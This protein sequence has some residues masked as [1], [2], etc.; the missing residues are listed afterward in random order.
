MFSLGLQTAHVRGITP[1]QAALRN[2]ALLIG[3]VTA[4]AGSKVAVPVKFQHGDSNV[5][6]MIFSVD[7]DQNC[8]SFSAADTNNDNIPDALAIF[9]PTSFFHWATFS[10]A[11]RGG[12]L[13]FAISALSALP[14]ADPLVMIEFTTTCTSGV[15]PVTFSAEPEASFGASGLAISGE[16][17]NGAVSITPTPPVSSLLLVSAGDTSGVVDGLAFQ[18]EDILAYDMA[19]KRWSLVFD[20]SDVGWA[21]VDLE[22]FDVLPDGSFLLTPSKKLV[23]PSLGEVLPS[24]ILRFIPTTLGSTTTGV[25]EWYFDGSDVGL[26]S[27][28][29]YIDA[30]ALDPS[31]RLLIS[32]EG[33]FDAGGVKGEDEDLF[34]FTKLTLGA[35]TTGSWMLYVDGSRIALTKSSEDIDAGWVKPNGDLYLSVKGKFAAV[36]GL[37][38]L[39]GDQNDIFICKPL[40]ISTATNCTFAPFFDGDPVRFTYNVDDVALVATNQLRPFTAISAAA[41][42]TDLEQ[43]AVGAAEQRGLT[44]DAELNEYDLDDDELLTQ[45]VFLPFIMQ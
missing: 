3:N 14:D 22:A 8:L 38:T 6:T 25:W 43:Y 11:D 4:A 16:T 13:D 23:I 37:S 24:D 18:D 33:A 15:T 32:S 5:D 36:S 41:A 20:G 31:G 21:K 26:S 2:P 10:A 17:T 30:I 42:G 1:T 29:E 44:V 12:E 19:G 40:T 35:N 9:A 39:S 28:S 45:K 7:Y 34:A 27:S